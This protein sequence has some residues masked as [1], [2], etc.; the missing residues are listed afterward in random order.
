MTSWRSVRG[1]IDIFDPY[2]TTI[3]RIEEFF[4]EQRILG[5]GQAGEHGYEFEV[6]I[7]GR[8][9][10]VA[11][12]DDAGTVIRGLSVSDLLVEMQDKLRK[13]AVELDGEVVHG[14]L[15]IGAVDI[16]ADIDVDE[17]DAVGA[18]V[19][20]ALESGASED[21]DFGVTGADFPDFDDGPMMLMTDMA[22]AEVPSL[23]NAQEAPIMVSKLG[24]LRVLTSERSLA[25]YRKVFPRPNYVMAFAVTI[26]GQFHPTLL[27]RRDNVRFTWDWSGELPV[28]RWID[29]GSIA[30]EFVNDELGAG[31]IARLATADLVNVT[32]A[33][34]RHALLVEP[35]AAVRT[36][37]RVLGLPH[38]IGEA[39]TGEGNLSNIPAAKLISPDDWSFED[40][41]AWEFAGEGIIE[42][43]MMK[44][45]NSIYLD[46]PWLVAVGSAFQSAIAGGLLATAFHRHRHGYGGK[47]LGVIGVGVLLSAFTRIGTTTYMRDILD[48][49]QADIDMWRN[50]RNWQ[51]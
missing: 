4:A 48:R 44:A 19:H 1:H 7:S 41:L 29:D 50:M 46:R 2:L 8:R 12:L 35:R 37:I 9:R 34:M 39:L 5:R 31:A 27:V 3:D 30:H 18:L 36:L 13:V 45:L 10:R 28:F 20:D 11:M 32:F 42:P 26:H 6:A 14:P 51:G 40:V 17:S 47:T 15:D 16:E 22:L 25:G 33:E 38:E 24:T 43:A 23:A 21:L 49:K